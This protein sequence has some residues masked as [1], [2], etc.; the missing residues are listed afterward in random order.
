MGDLKQQV[1]SRLFTR[2][3]YQIMGKNTIVS[4]VLYLHCAENDPGK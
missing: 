1:K 2:F 3:A 4:A